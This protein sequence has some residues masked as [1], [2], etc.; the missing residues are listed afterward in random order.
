M[1]RLGG[2]ADKFGNRYESLWAVDAVLDLIEGE[3]AEAVFEAVGE[4]DSG[5]EFYRTTRSGT[6]E[7]HSI[8]RQQSDGNWTVSRLTRESSPPG[9][10]ILGN[11]IRKI[12]AGAEGVFSSGTSASELEE[13]TARAQASDS[14]W[15][16]RQRIDQNGQLAGCFDGAIVRICGSEEAAYAALRRLRVRTK[17]EP[18]LTKD[19]ERRVRS[20]LQTY[21]GEPVDATAVRLLVADFITRSLGAQLTAESFLEHLAN[22]GVLPS[23]LRADASIRQRIGRL[24]RRYLSE[25]NALLIN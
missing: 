4:E 9:R 16:F 7:Y 3:F 24:N 11:L 22:H 15:N 1:P 19:V 2:E 10:S 18:E 17:N 12:Q 8:K 5:V 20:T 23:H 25:V 21:S 13:L 6:R 14:I